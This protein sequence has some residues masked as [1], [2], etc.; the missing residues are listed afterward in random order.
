MKKL[1]T[2]LFVL[3]VSL[4]SMHAQIVDFYNKLDDVSHTLSKSNLT[5]DSNLT[6]DDQVTLYFIDIADWNI[7]YA[8]VWSDSGEYVSWPGEKTQWTGEKVNG[9]NIYS[10]TFPVQYSN[11]IFSGGGQTQDLVWNLSTPY[12]TIDT[13][14]MCENWQGHTCCGI[15]LA[16]I[17]PSKCGDNLYWDFNP[18]NGMISITG[19][20]D[21]Y[22]YEITETPWNT[23]CE[24]IYALSLPEGMTSIGDN[25]FS[26][27]SN[28]SS[29]TIPDSVT[30]I[31]KGAF[32]YCSNLT[33]VT[34]GDSVSSIGVDAFAHCPIQSI[35][36]PNSVTT[37][38]A[39]AF[40]DCHNMTS[41]TFGNGVKKIGECA[42]SRCNSLISI[43]IPNNVKIIDQEAFSYCQNLT[44]V[45]IGSGLTCIKNRLFMG[46]ESL[47]SIT[48]GNTV[49]SI[50]DYAFMF[51]DNLN[52]IHYTG[53]IVDWCAK[54]W[55]PSFISTDYALYIEGQKVTDL[56]IPD[57]VAKIG[58]YA[59][60]CC[61]SLTTLNIPNTYI[62]TGAF[63]QC[64]KLKTVNIGNGVLG[65]GNDA[66]GTCLNLS[67][68]TIGNSVTSI[69]TEAFY[70]CTSLDTIYNNAETPQPIEDNVFGGVNKSN[71]RLIVPTGS[72]ALYKAAD[73]WKEFLIE[74]KLCIADYGMCGEY[75]GWTVNCDS[76]ELWIEG[77]G[78]MSDGAP[79][80]E[81]YGSI[82]KIIL[83]KGI[84]RIGAGAFA[85][86]SI[87]KITIPGKVNSIGAEAFSGC[88]S[89]SSIVC[90]AVTPPV[91][92]AN[93][94]AGVNKSIP[95]V[96]PERS[97][98]AYKAAD[99][100]QDFFPAGDSQEITG[101]DTIPTV[102]EVT[103]LY[104]LTG[105]NLV[106]CLYFDVAPCNDVY[107]PGNYR[108]NA[109]GGWSTDINELERF[110]PLPGFPGWY[111][112]EVPYMN[113]AQGKP[114]QLRSDDIFDWE[115]QSGDANAWIN[116]GTLE[117]TVVSGYPGEADI[118]YPVPGCYIY[119]L[120]YWKNHN[121]PCMIVPKHDYTIRLYAPD[122]CEEMKPAV[123][124]SF[125]NWSD[126][127]PMKESTDEQGKTVY[128]YTI[129]DKEGNT[130][131]FVDPEYG[132]SNQLQYYD[133][134]YGY[135]QNF[136]NYI[137][138][139]TDQDTTLVF[140]YSENGKY[141]FASCENNVPTIPSGINNAISEKDEPRKLLR[142][143]Q[144]LILRGEKVYTLQ[145][146][147]VKQ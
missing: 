83:D 78:V 134:E 123:V 97:R 63:N 1:L 126:F 46:C 48:L 27:C 9:K 93:V 40:Y 25:A 107:F 42:F 124:G 73:V 88:S 112:V 28:L 2:I 32:H 129:Y 139:E 106:V 29:V 113:N 60:R 130:F 96:I 128:T 43:D 17:P 101:P 84:T 16:D 56:I 62:G 103:Q 21:M 99:Q 30:S 141:R 82:R 10:Y 110:E 76:T 147:E 132:W 143:G 24:Q 8:Y 81:Y 145:G 70:Y 79:W 120:A 55:M 37:I 66:F 58:Y 119:E 127:V 98:E 13:T 23:Y 89:L 146:V 69:G 125:N 137:L 50:E 6:L 71:C 51:C 133:L 41:I 140:D 105:N 68:V 18:E 116:H 95:L 36:I 65:I 135:W 85:G 77:S 19:Y 72:L 52:A 122:A 53:S 87:A 131:K 92:D 118:Y 20:G 111:V 39:Y 114:V 90:E 121:T 35:D 12:C 117:A 14:T 75:V 38:E 94:F 11:I 4:E 59:F 49:T 142:D 5:A 33:K 109:S 31:G 86:A 44:D 61:M 138:P 80:A 108:M 67:K 15:W 34:I 136:D 26:G 47:S 74:E 144:L 102:E 45:V 104:P 3:M 7:V 115:Y 57:E 22:N 91:C 54:S 100:W 64:K